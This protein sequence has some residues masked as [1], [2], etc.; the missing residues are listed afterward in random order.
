MTENAQEEKI[1]AVFEGSHQILK[2]SRSRRECEE[3]ILSFPLRERRRMVL[4]ER[5]VV[6]MFPY[7]KVK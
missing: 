1:Y 6:G 7:K 2:M 4:K 3:Y 5:P